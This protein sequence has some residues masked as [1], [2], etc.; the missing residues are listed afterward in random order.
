MST[1]WAT[2]IITATGLA[3]PWLVIVTAIIVR[4]VVKVNSIEKSHAECMR[5]RELI[6]DN[7]NQLMGDLRSTVITVSQDIKWIR[8]SLNRKDILDVQDHE[9]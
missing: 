8:K 4:L 9:E 6:E 3:I 2:V 5:R 1:E 7:I